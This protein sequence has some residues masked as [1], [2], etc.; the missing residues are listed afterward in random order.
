MTKQIEQGKAFEYACL[1]C[2]YESLRHTQSVSIVENESYN[3]AKR[4]YEGVGEEMQSSLDQASVAAL[5]AI[6]RLEPRLKHPDGNEPL[7]ISLQEDAKGKD[8]DVRDVL[9]IRQKNGWEIGISCKHNHKALKHSRLSNSL[10]FGAK[11]FG[12][13]CSHDYFENIAPIFDFL[14]KKR[15]E[16]ALWRD[17]DDKEG[18]VYRPLMDA[19]KE[20]IMR[21]DAENP[22]TIPAALIQYLVGRNDFYKIIADNSRKVSE[23][24]GFNLNGTLNKAS[25]LSKPETTIPKLSLPTC[26]LKID[27]KKSSRNTILISCDEG[28]SISLRVHNASSKIEP[29]LKLDIQLKGIPANFYR[30]IVLWS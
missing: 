15:E 17:L 2:L 4:Y 3:I 21:L 22:E 16:K 27:Y 29:S 19:F 9:C 5:G 11:W 10:D 23:I 7:I 20:E 14:A 6:L 12:V 8:G 25:K 28:W 1:L 13:P 26:L 18:T 24:E 30:Q